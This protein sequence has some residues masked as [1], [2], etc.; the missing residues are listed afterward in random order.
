MNTPLERFFNQ[1]FV[2]NLAHR[3]D[4]RTQ[5]TE[6]LAAIGVTNYEWF[7]GHCAPKNHEGRP[8]ANM[9]CTASHR[10]LLEIIAHRRWPKVLI[11]EDDAFF[12][13]NFHDRFSAAIS[14]APPSFDFL[15]LGGSY[16][17]TPKKR[18]NKHWIQTNGLMTT[19]SYGITCEMARK[20][21]P[22]ISGDV[23]IDSLYHQF[24]R[25]N[26]CYM[27]TPR[28]V[29]QRPSYSDIQERDCDNSMSMLDS[30]HEE[31]FIEGRWGETVG[32]LRSFK[33]EIMRREIAAQHDMDGEIVIIGDRQWKIAALQLPKHLPPWRR[34]ELV[35]YILEAV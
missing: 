34:G 5:I 22:H 4:R 31:M 21:A 2:V 35:T 28:L 16:A 20:M 12:L 7:V 18:F 10:G 26:L 30:R 6:A 9:G 32:N 13:E 14:D 3:T 17:E 33:G 11:L 15:F 24:Q 23:G 27:M 19:S 25:D 8:S 1:I 29:V